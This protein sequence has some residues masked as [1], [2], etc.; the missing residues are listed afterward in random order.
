M[1]QR[2]AALRSTLLSIEKLYGKQTLQAVKDAVP[3]EHRV[4][5]E[6]PALA[7]TWYPVEV[8]AALQVA[9]KNVIGRGTW[10]ASHRIGVEAARVDFTGIYRVLLRAVQ[11]DSIWDRMERAWAHYN[12]QGDA[13]WVDRG[14]GTA[15]GR[16]TGVT[17]FNPGIWQAVAGRAEGLLVLAG[18]RAAS[19]SVAE[20]S[21]RSA[22][23]EAVW[24]E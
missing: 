6:E 2:G 10:N 12:S 23:I 3:D 8:S 18:V 15:T 11:Y 21:E 4:R 7:V 5:L 20:G 24:L 1:K 17:G 14:R 9:I 19:V 16:I 13:K 22:R